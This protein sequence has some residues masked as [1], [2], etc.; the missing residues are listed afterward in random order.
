MPE[1]IP[2][3]NGLIG[4]NQNP[5]QLPDQPAGLINLPGFNRGIITEK[6]LPGGQSH[7][8]LFQRGISCPFA[9]SINCAFNLACSAFDS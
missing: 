2:A 1:G 6:V 8:N 3:D 4:L 7:N 9:N 5:G